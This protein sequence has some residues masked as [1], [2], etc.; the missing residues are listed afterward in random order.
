MGPLR[1]IM[2]STRGVYSESP[3]RDA[4]WTVEET[5]GSIEF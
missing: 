1:P 2:L 4:A 5:G 3:A